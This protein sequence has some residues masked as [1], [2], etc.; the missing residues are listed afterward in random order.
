VNQSLQM[1]R[2][3]NVETLL[4]VL[5]L[6]LS[7]TVTE[8]VKARAKKLLTRLEQN[9]VTNDVADLHQDSVIERVMDYVNE[10]YLEPLSLEGIAEK[11]HRAPAHLTTRFRQATGLPVME[12]V[13][14]KR[15][16][17]AKHLL[18]TTSKTVQAIAEYVGYSDLSLFSRQFRRRFGV[19]P[20]QWR[21]RASEKKTNFGENA[22]I[23]ILQA[24]A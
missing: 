6:S 19:S 10:H 18:L 24:N 15:M 17:E 1:Q 21:E 14:E 8:K 3:P 20:S 11:F 4:Q 22:V 7:Q 16:G 2:E 13:L 12:C 9:Q 23:H 5:E